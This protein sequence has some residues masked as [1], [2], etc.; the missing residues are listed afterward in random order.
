MIPNKL[1][2]GN[3]G[4]VLEVVCK[5]DA[6]NTVIDLTGM[7]VNLRYRIAGGALKT[8]AMTVVTPQTGDNKGKATYQFTAADDLYAAGEFAGDVDVVDGSS[9]AVTNLDTI[10]LQVREPLA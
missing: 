10:S 7:T 3:K 6:T 4:S 2:K 1:V 9:N 5:D 8:R